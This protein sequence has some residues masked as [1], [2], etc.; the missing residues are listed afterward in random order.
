MN[1]NNTHY[2]VISIA[3]IRGLQCYNRQ[4][5]VEIH[6]A[7]KLRKQTPYVLKIILQRA[8]FVDVREINTHYQNL[9]FLKVNKFISFLGLQ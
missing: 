8:L 2:I 5:H 6:M 7:Y 4:R 3:P 9:R 1:S